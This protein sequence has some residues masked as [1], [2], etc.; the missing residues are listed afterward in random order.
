MTRG[1][2]HGYSGKP[3]AQKL[4]LGPGD[5]LALLNPPERALAL[6]SPLPPGAEIRYDIRRR[7]NVALAFFDRK[8]RLRS[9]LP[10]LRRAIYPD[11]MLWIAWPKRASGVVTD[12]DE[13][14]VRELA[15]EHDLVDTKVM[16]IDATWSGLKLVVPVKL[17][18]RST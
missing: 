13:N 2:Q 10:S 9:R 16:A 3:V 15:L 5:V 8:A 17:R 12:I 7:P 1:G 14:V 18:G 6:L 4:G 11:Q